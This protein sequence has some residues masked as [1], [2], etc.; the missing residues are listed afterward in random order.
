MMRKRSNET[1][2]TTENTET[3]RRRENYEISE[4]KR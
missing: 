1:L 4:R 2:L 3:Q